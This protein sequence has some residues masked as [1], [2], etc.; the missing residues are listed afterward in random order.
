MRLFSLSLLLGTAALAAG[1][2][3]VEEPDEDA[4]RENTSFN[5]KLVPPMTILTPLTW[6]DEMA[7]GKYTMVKGYRCVVLLLLCLCCC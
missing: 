6:D 4:V 3:L 2:A 7:K 1:Q 5:G